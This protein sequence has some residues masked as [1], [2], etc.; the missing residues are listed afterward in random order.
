MTKENIIIN[1]DDNIT[2]YV[3]DI[4]GS[5]KIDILSYVTKIAEYILKN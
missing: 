5:N 3:K 1:F 2:A 4:F